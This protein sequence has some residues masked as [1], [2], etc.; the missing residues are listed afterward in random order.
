MKLKND[1]RELPVD[2]IQ[3]GP[4][5]RRDLGTVAGLAASIADLGLL[6]PIAI[7]PDGKLVA[8]RRR[9]AA[10]KLL[11]WATVPVHVV[12]G[13]GDALR[14]LRA[15]QHENV[16]RIPFLPT[17]LV[18]IGLAVEALERPQARERQGRPGSARSGKL[19]EHGDTRDKVA[20]ALGTSGRT[21]EKAKAVVL[22]AEAD[23]EFFGDL[24]TMMDA[25]GT[26]DGAFQELRRRRRRLAREAGWAARAAAGAALHLE[27]FHHGDFRD[28]AKSIPDGSVDLVFT[29]PPYTRDCL[30]LY[31]ALAEVA[32]AKLV[33][34]GSLVCYVGQYLLPDVLNLVMPHLRYWW[35]AAAIHTEPRARMREYGVKVGWKPLLWFVKGRWDRHTFVKDTLF[36][37]M[38]K[39]DHPYQ[40]SVEE[41]MYFVGKLVPEGGLVWDPFCGGGTT[42]AACKQLGVRCVTCDVYAQALD[43]AKARVA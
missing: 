14:L 9:L 8:G 31:G 37:T 39:A 1:R 15:E 43:R 25:T 21:Y 30:P 26:V 3:I 7:T 5:H 6:Q 22:A 13:L 35:T 19:P 40:Q 41:A 28:V 11:G 23:P 34:G 42:A 4:R 16:C 18:S 38:E 29:D 24:P 20:G 27:G 33:E 2:R 12:R 32:A 17:E 36:S 10:V